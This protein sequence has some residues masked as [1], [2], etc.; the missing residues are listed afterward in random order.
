ML[1]RKA[2]RIL[3]STLTQRRNAHWKASAPTSLPGSETFAAQS[4]LSK[5][6]VPEL[7]DTLARLKESLKPIAWNDDEYRT[8]VSKIDEFGAGLGPVLHDRLI[9]RQKETD[10]WLER[11]WDDGAYLG[12]RDS[13]SCSVRYMEFI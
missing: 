2:H 10:H 12:Y 6:P 1:S 8:V 7:K 4:S 11:W 5:L 9:N 13:V 3:M